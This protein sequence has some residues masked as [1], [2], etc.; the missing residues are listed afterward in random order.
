MKR[1]KF[2]NTLWLFFYLSIAVVYARG[3]FLGIMDVDSAQYA[4]ISR[5][6]Y[7]SGEYLMVRH[8]ERDYL[9]KPPFLFWTAALSY[10][11]FGINEFAFRFFSFVFSLIGVYATYRLGR[12]LYNI[13]VGKVAALILG[14]TQAWF[15]FNHDVRTDTI[16]AGSAVFATWQII[17]HLKTK[18]VSNFLAGF[19][20][21][22]IAMLSK[23]PIGL[24]V[25]AI[26]VGTYLI[27]RGCWYKLLHWK[28]LA[29]VL[30]VLL[31]LSPMIYGLYMQYD[32]QPQKEI[33]LMT[34]SGPQVYKGISGIK[35]YFWT[36]SFGRITG[37][38][39]WQD[40]SSAFFFVHNFL[41][42]FAPWS[43]VACIALFSRIKN[44]FFQDKRYKE[45][46]SSI[47]FLVAFLAF[48]A[49][50]FKLPHYLFIVYP[51]AAIFTAY[52][53]VMRLP[54]LS[55]WV[56]NLIVLQQYLVA[57]FSGILALYLMAVVF[58]EKEYSSVI[59]WFTGISA[60]IISLLKLPYT[61]AILAAGAFTGVMFNGVLN[62][63]F[64]PELF[65]YQPG[66]FLA[67]KIQ[68]LNISP[69][70]VC[71]SYPRSIHALEFYS[72]HIFCQAQ[73]I[74]PVRSKYWIC[75]DEQLKSLERQGIP[76]E[77]LYQRPAFHITL[78]NAEFLNPSTRP[79]TLSQV[80]FIK[81]YQ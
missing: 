55:G 57:F 31:L 80:Y 9:D 20:A 5:E 32:A 67:E 43:I 15:L 69:S 26:A 6:M 56:K 52:Y 1:W 25:P 79:K 58:P 59:L 42:S 75:S 70:E 7:E 2:E 11:L 29:G 21:I 36:Q 48:S 54:K 23:G 14:T 65:E 60:I 40:K 38:S 53:M 68:E 27:S 71:I 44:N 22:A 47:T 10:R 72:R 35:F 77:L 24:I 49:S 18:R 4:S 17:Y 50:R 13:W 8:Q 76:Y 62:F 78:L 64:Y 51:F 16:L 19:T 81:L 33:E 41:W 37:Q 34:S 61:R 63:R 30:W 3:L 46:V 12:L 73:D 45:W 28:W 74:S 39:D 66:Y